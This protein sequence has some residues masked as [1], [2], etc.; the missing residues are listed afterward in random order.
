LEG[1]TS[2]C[3]CFFLGLTERDRLRERERGRERRFWGEEAPCRPHPLMA[4]SLR[5]RGQ[6]L[7]W[8]FWCSDWEFHYY[9][10]LNGEN[11]WCSV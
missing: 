9:L 3:F 11:F 8:G 7:G 4:P 1:K 10:Y 2:Y 5:E 6:S